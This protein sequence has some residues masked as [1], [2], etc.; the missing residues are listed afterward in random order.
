MS[1]E[2]QQEM[3]TFFETEN[4]LYGEAECCRANVILI[5]PK[6][7]YCA[8]LG[9]SRSVLSLSGKAVSLS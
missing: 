1:E 7:I 2:G 3:S 9:D 6:T 4:Q 8:N 5:T